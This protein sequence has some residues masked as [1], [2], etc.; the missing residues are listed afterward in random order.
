LNCGLQNGPQRRVSLQAASF[1][2][3]VRSGLDTEN[4]EENVSVRGG[5]ENFFR[6][7]SGKGCGWGR[8]GSWGGQ[9]ERRP[10]GLWL[11]LGYRLNQSRRPAIPAA[12]LQAAGAGVVVM[13]GAASAH[14]VHHSVAPGRAGSIPCRHDAASKACNR[15]LRGEHRDH[16][17]G[18]ELEEFPHALRKNILQRAQSAV[19]RI[20]SVQSPRIP[21]TTH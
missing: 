15:R 17:D 1:A 13:H 2:M 12:I 9:Q 11:G 5:G 3:H 4:L 20:T 14:V 8:R 7:S 6:R 18:D 21:A 10:A 19:M 16:G